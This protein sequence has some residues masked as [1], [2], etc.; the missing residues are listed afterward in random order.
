MFEDLKLRNSL[1]IERYSE[2]KNEEELIKQKIIGKL[3]EDKNCFNNMSIED[4]FSIF[5]DLGYSKEESKSLYIK[6]TN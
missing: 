2:E 1:L 4:A 3:I 5:R 6:L